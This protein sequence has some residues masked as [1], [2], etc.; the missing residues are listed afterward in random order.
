MLT[1]AIETSCDETGVALLRSKGLFS[2]ELLLDL[3]SSQIATHN[4]Y[5][6]VVPRLAAREHEANL[7]LLAKKAFEKVR[8]EK[9][10][11]THIAYTAYPGLE[12]ALLIG[13]TFARTLSWALNIPSYPI[14][15]L[16]GH[17]VSALLTTDNKELKNNHLFPAIGLVVSGGHTQLYELA[18]F[19]KKNLLGETLDDAI[20][21]AFDKVGR[22]LG[23]AY[24]GGPRLETLARQGAQ[25]KI[26]FP[27]PL[28]RSGDCRFSFSGLKT[29]VLYFLKA[30]K[31]PLGVKA[32]A[33]IAYAF[34]EAVLKPIIEK[35][36]Q[37]LAHSGARSLFLGGGVAA[38][39]TLQEKLRVLIT[40]QFPGVALFIP[41]KEFATDNAAMIALAHNLAFLTTQQTCR[42]K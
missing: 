3:F 35:T 18:S 28:L 31:K 25:T 1:L 20:G 5:G 40:G 13:K 29:S 34:Q 19:T 22:L 16:D 41:K 27:S 21:E 30:Q 33:E 2:H 9:L 14:N 32:K 10:T 26:T 12:P 39:E 38:N 36:R 4:P 6:G 23:L 15:H 42:K 37:A 8:R 11:I 24:P 17:I 7:P